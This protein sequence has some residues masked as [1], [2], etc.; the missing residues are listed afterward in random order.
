MLISLIIE[1]TYQ[2]GIGNIV[3][4]VAGSLTTVIAHNLATDGDTMPA[5]Q[6]VLDTN[7]W[8]ATHVTIINFG[9]AAT[10]VAGIL[11]RAFRDGWRVYQEARPESFRLACVKLLYGTVCLARS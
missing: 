2:N 8:L 3:A 10:F 11:G 7:F 9:Y 5:L 4:S 1:G 6:A